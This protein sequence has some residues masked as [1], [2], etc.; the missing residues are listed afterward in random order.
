VAPTWPDV[1]DVRR[2]A[3]RVARGTGALQ[4]GS[5][6]IADGHAREARRL[7]AK[8]AGGR[9]TSACGSVLDYLILE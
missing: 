7:V 9:L 5:E 6:T 8:S 3:I 1:R 4:N 2:E